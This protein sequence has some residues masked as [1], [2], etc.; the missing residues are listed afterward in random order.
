MYKVMIRDNMSPIA[1]QILEDTGKIEVVVDNDKAANDPEVLAG[2]IDSYDGIAVRSSTKI[3]EKV[4]ENA[5]KLKVI[6][7]AGVGVDNIDQAAATREGIVVMNAPG[8]NTVTTAE[9][10]VSMMFALARN[11]PQATASLRQGRWDKKKLTGVEITGKTLGIVGLGYV[12]RAVADR[13]RGLKMKVIAADPYV[14]REAADK[15]GVRLAGLEELFAE[16]DFITMH[17][18]GLKETV[19]MIN[20]DTIAMMKPGV[21]IINCSRGNVINLDDLYQAVS[22]GHVAGAALDVFPQEPPD[23]SMPIIQH[24]NMI[25]TP[26]LG[27]S[28]GEAQINV[29]RMIAEQIAGYLI[30]GIITNAVNFPAVSME[31]MGQLRPYLTLAE[32][33]GSMMGQLVRAV[34][35]VTISYS[36]E[37]STLSMR[38]VTH[39]LLK[40]LLG[41]FTHE[42]VNYVNAR[43]IAKDK[44]IGIKETVE[45]SDHA[46]STLIKLKLEGTQESPDEIW[47]TIY[48]KQYPRLIRI[49]DVYLDAIPEGYMIVIQNIDKP[50]VIGNV[51]T[52]LGHHNI[53]IGRFQLGRRDDR[54]VCL[55]N[56]D[57]PADQNVLEEIRALPNMIS[58][59]QVNLG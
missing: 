13:A 27:A 51:G 11:I 3:T 26:H 7:R 4:L 9:H 22:S 46:F 32:K 45:Q 14:S 6:G 48:E 59:R 25:M 8:G 21:R 24:P 44:G 54:A 41:S 33:M 49:G 34:H 52:A 12:G 43:A 5:K 39:A 42:P 17:V 16:S 1:K 40:G 36:G 18:P 47:G 15:L 38:P 2:I 58:V 19:N 53:N 57:T 31:E 28:T 20:A 55:V 56:I 10:A 30:N 37:V 23:S 50:G 35:N 29:A